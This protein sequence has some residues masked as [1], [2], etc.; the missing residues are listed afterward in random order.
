MEHEREQS[1]KLIR[2]FLTIPGGAQ[3]I[4]RNAVSSL[5]AI[6]EATDDKMNSIALETLMEISLQ[7]LELVAHAGGLKPVIIIIK[8]IFLIFFFFLLKCFKVRFT[9]LFNL[10]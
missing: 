1:L 8:K 6:A 4:P 7:N 2:S 5:V 9:L 10:I 3:L